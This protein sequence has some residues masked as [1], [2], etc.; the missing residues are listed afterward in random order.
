ME[1]LCYWLIKYSVIEENNSE[2]GMEN[3]DTAVGTRDS[4]VTAETL[5]F[6]RKRARKKIA[7]A[8]CAY[9]ER[10]A[11][12]LIKKSLLKWFMKKQEDKLNSLK[13]RFA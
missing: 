6:G 8:V 4:P 3:N 2:T 11:R 1:S 5:E 9:K 10:K 12:L 7:A 13:D